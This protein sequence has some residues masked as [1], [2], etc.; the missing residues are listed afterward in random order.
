MTK[1]EDQSF[2]LCL[3]HRQDSTHKQHVLI[4]KYILRLKNL[5]LFQHIVVLKFAADFIPVLVYYGKISLPYK[6]MGKRAFH[7]IEGNNTTLVIPSIF[8]LVSSGRQFFPVL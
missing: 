1:A 5:Y 2:A 7:S 4:Q 6:E 8:S 3:V